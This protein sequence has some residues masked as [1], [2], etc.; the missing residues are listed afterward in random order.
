MYCPQTGATAYRNQYNKY[1]NGRFW[2]IRFHVRVFLILFLSSGTILQW[3]Q[4][5]QK[6]FGNRKEI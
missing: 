3:Q 4:A 2:G 5:Y 1:N 6:D